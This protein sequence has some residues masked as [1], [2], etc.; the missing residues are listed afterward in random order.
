VTRRTAAKE[1]ERL[2]LDHG[3]VR[4]LL[5]RPRV[6]PEKAARVDQVDTSTDMYDTPSGGDIM[7]V[8]ASPM[9]GKRD[10]ILTS[11]LGDV[12]KESARA[13]WTY[14]RAHADWLS[15]DNEADLD[16]LPAEVRDLLTVSPVDRSPRRSRSRCATRR[17]ATAAC[18]S[19]ITAAPT[20][21]DWRT[22]PVSEV[23]PQGK[24]TA[25]RPMPRGVAPCLHRQRSREAMRSQLPVYRDTF[26]V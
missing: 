1:I 9:R 18:S 5:G 25:Q 3:E 21:S 17:C 12:M 15:R 10:L 23:R 6:H 20:S 13:A 2:T 14:A 22:E 7:F 26:P 16:D 11:Q 19:A 8:E 4:P 24:R